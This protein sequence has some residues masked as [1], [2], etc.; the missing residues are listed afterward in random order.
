MS[1]TCTDALVAALEVF[2]CLLVLILLLNM[3]KIQFNHYFKKV[4]M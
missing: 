1:S 4:N 3:V 2:Y